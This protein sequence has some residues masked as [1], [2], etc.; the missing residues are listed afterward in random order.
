MEFEELA[1]LTR[2][3]GRADPVLVAATREVLLEELALAWTLDAPT[4]GLRAN[5]LYQYRLSL[6]LMARAGI[7]KVVQATP[8]AVRAFMKTRLAAGRSPETC[9]RNL[10]ALTS[11][12]TWLHADGRVPLS[13]LLELRELYLARPHM[14]P[15]AFLERERY[16]V[17]REI[18]RA[19]DPVGRFELLVAFGVE[20]GLRW[21]EARQLHAE[22]LALA[23][24]EP[25]VRVSLTH[26]RRNKT[27][28]T[29]AVPI[30]L[31][32]AQELLALEL[33]PGPIFPARIRAGEDLLSP[34]LHKGTWREWRK[35]SLA[36][37]GFWNWNLL[38]HTFASWHVQAGVPID[39]VARWLG[40]GVDVAKKHYAGHIPGGDKIV[41]VTFRDVPTFGSPWVGPAPEALAG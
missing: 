9:N 2:D 15:P 27:D 38:R 35:A 13:Q 32:F 40:C 23:I 14:P 31:A 10:A 26:G 12:M 24:A 7:G 22:D 34:Y 11:L 16:R 30:R 20:S 3:V 18:T 25:Y 37:A 33:E 6:G 4:T 8:L 1:R 29:R 5:T 41:E 19:I 21:H 17:I 28:R 36:R 39:D